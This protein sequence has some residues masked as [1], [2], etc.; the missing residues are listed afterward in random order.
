M[1]KLKKT[2]SNG[3]EGRRTLVTTRKENVAKMM[4]GTI[5]M[6]TTKVCLIGIVGKSLNN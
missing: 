3:A 6:I 2:F 1:G 4:R 5:N